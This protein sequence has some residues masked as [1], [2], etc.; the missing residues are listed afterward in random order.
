[1]PR[2]GFAH[3]PLHNGKAPRWLFT[4]MTQLAR[5][6]TRAIVNNAGSQEFLRRISD[7]IWFQA[8]GCVLGFD[9]H[10]SGVTTTVC[11][12]LKEGIKGL[13]GELGIFIAGGKGRS[14]RKTP[15]HITDYCQFLAPQLNPALLIEKS[16][17]SAKIDNTALQDGYQLYHHTFFFNRNGHWAVVQQG[18]NEEN[19]YARRYHWLSET[20]TDMVNEPH[21]GVC[22]DVK[23]QPLNL[24][25][26]QS[27]DSR[28]AIT[29][30]TREHPEKNL[31]EFKKISALTLPAHHPVYW[32]DVQPRHL[33]KVLIST[34]ERSPADFKQVLLTP[35]LGPKS[36]RALTLLAEVVLGAKPSFEDP[37]QYSFSHGGKDGYPYPVNRS[38]YERSI[39][40]LREAVDKARVGEYEKMRALKRLETYY[41]L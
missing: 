28:L 3:L 40:V 20:I 19:R 13:E 37:V 35:G 9:W 38:I 27:S 32:S 36:L 2:S 1:M 39:F 5:E 31:R 18:M 24:V 12:A 6:I 30:L 23:T 8:L 7:P 10:S 17:L 41:S 33:E 34:Y 11:G 16:R 21:A 29:T 15:Q 4:L 25:A 14:S 22:C 26:R